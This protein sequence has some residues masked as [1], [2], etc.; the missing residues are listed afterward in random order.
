MSLP[1]TPASEDA[2]SPDPATVEHDPFDYLPDATLVVDGQWRVVRANAAARDLLGPAG[3]GAGEVGGFWRALPDA[4]EPSRQRLYRA[5]LVADG[6]LARFDQHLAD[7]DAWFSVR[8]RPVPPGRLLVTLTDVTDLRRTDADLAER[9]QRYRLIF[10]RSPLPIFVYD[11]QTMR[12]TM[13]N[14]A[15]VTQYGFPRSELIGTDG[16]DLVAPADVPHLRD[17]ISGL[18]STADVRNFAI[19]HRRRDGSIFPIESTSHGFVVA[20]RHVRA[21]LAVDVTDRARAERELRDSEQR[22]RSLIETADSIVVAMDPDHRIT[23]WNGAAERVSG[24]ARE[25]VLGRNYHQLFVP[26]EL[27]R[28]VEVEADQLIAGGTTRGFEGILLSRWGHRRT[29]LWNAHR[30]TDP[31]GVPS[32][33][34]AVAQDITDRKRAEDALRASEHLHRTLGDA[35]PQL[36]WTLSADGA[37]EYVNA[38]FT[39]FT[40]LALGDLARH[41]HGDAAWG[42]FVHPDDLP[43]LIARWTQDRAAAAAGEM[44]VRWCGGHQCTEDGHWFLVRHAPLTDP[45]GRVLRW[46]GTATDVDELKRAQAD[47]RRAKEAADH[48]R[49]AAEH[50]NEAKDQFLAVLSHELRTPLTPVLLTAS[51]LQVDP[52]LTDDVREAV[53]MIVEQ[54]ELEAKL[55]D[56]LLDLT[57]IARGKFILN[58]QRL[59]GHDLVRRA[60]EVCRATIDAAGVALAVDLSAAAR[61]LEADPTRIQQVLCNLLANAA[62]FTPAGGRLRVRTWNEL[63]DPTSPAAPGGAAAGSVP[64]LSRPEIFAIEVSDTGVGI[65]AD[66]LPR[67]FNAFEQGERSITRRFGGLGL[68]LTIGR[69]IADMHGGTLSAASD[70]RDR[71]ATLTLRL[72]VVTTAVPTAPDLAPAAPAGR[73]LRVLLVD[74]HVPTLRMMSRLV[75][76]LGHDVRAADS[77]AAALELARASCPDLLISDIGMPNQSGWALLAEIHAVCPVPPVAM[78]VSGYGTDDDLRRSRTAGFARHLVKPIGLA[79]LRTAIDAVMGEETRP[80]QAPGSRARPADA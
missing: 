25:E 54:V 22:Y 45:L 51:A 57:R 17:L 40:G 70:G 49:L 73:P 33:I 78:A 31:A 61:S 10:E 66:V 4:A 37:F 13:A 27:R 79:D 21:V 47:L 28:S 65:E 5:A 36:M 76:S 35:M 18:H 7:R 75:T 42:A 44:E 9:E 30:A 64:A 16:T 74:D 12:I 19:R 48:A 23:E 20:G 72:P 58:L 32:G 3:A 56:D 39:D 2:R 43:S 53:A 77:P 8:C 50:A 41:G 38:R 71:G 55:I 26:P 15:A 1:A 34:V 6:P 60:V 59:D 67:I 52:D 63:P 29:L 11:V 14:D 80:D 24:Y 46:V 68:G 62:K 69:T